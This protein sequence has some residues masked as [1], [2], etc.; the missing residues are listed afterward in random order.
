MCEHLCENH[1]GNLCE[2]GHDRGHERGRDKVMNN[3]KQSGIVMTKMRAG[4]CREY[5]YQATLVFVM[6]THGYS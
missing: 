5:V 1:R 3:H 2:R 4:L 6:T